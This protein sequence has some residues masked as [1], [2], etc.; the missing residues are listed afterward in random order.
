MVE[1][2]SWSTSPVVLSW[3]GSLGRMAGPNNEIKITVA[4]NAIS[5]TLYGLISYPL[6]VSFQWTR[7]VWSS[8]K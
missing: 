6:N 1:S 4:G 5:F 7:T 2:V 8:A 3:S